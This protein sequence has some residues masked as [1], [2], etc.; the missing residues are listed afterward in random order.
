MLILP[1][2][3]QPLRLRSVAEFPEYEAQQKK[4]DGFRAELKRIQTRKSEI[5][6]TPRKSWQ[7]DEARARELLETGTL[8]ADRRESLAAEYQR[9]DMDER[10]YDRAVQACEQQTR[11]LVVRLSRQVSEE[12]KPAHKAAVKRVLEALAELAAANAAELRVREGLTR[13]GLNCC[14]PSLL[15]SAAG[16]LNPAD[17]NDTYCLF[18]REVYAAGYLDP[19][20]PL[21]RSLADRHGWRD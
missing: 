12:V 15:F 5:E 17:Q 21:W 10:V 9:L 7:E 3:A 18:V 6:K 1:K 16:P 13:G 11:D 8:R 4:F 2:P 20:D 19:K 14:L